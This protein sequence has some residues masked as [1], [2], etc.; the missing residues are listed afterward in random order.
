VSGQRLWNLFATRF[1]QPKDFFAEHIV[2]NYCPLAF[3]EDTGRNRTPDKL[4][5]KEKEALF[6]ACD[7]HL[8]AVVGALQ[9]KWLIGIGGFA[10][11]RAEMVF[12]QG[13]IKLGRILHPSP[14]NPTA[15]QNWAGTVTR[16][17]EALGVW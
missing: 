14:A 13:G 15:N 6:T 12:G 3:L 10:S 11:E 4:A 16:Q 17:L 7:E 2:M 5:P 1:R 8:R 9:P